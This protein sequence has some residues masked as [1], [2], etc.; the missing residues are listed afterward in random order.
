MIAFSVVLK[1]VNNCCV[2]RC[3]NYV[4]EKQ[5]ISFTPFLSPINEDTPGGK[6][7]YL[8]YVAILS[9]RL[10]LDPG[11]SGYP[12]VRPGKLHS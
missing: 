5:G 12:C 11:E 6:H 1:I 2:V 8:D 9:H 10:L 4:G 3:K 7:L